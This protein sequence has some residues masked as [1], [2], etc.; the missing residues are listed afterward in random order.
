MASSR[1][2]I[3]AFEPIES[4]MNKTLCLFEVGILEDLEGWMIW[5]EL[6]E[7]AAVEGGGEQEEYVRGN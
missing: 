5:P 4:A 3:S 7:N 6:L 2:L 1:C